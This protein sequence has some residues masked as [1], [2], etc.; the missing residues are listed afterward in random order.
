[1]YVGYTELWWKHLKIYDH[2]QPLP[3]NDITH[4]YDI[5]HAYDITHV[6]YIT[7]SYDITHVYDI[8]QVFAPRG[9][10][11]CTDLR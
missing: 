2:I 4:V 9:L 7:H 1:M 6:Y 3:V 11:L 10:G 8:T 5:T